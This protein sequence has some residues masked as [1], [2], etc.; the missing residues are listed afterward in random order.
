MKIEDYA[1]LSDTQ[2]AA[3]D[4]MARSIGFVSR[5]S[6]PGRVSPRSSGIGRMADGYSRRR[7]KSPPRAGV[8]AMAR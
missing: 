1:F 8:T 5:N 4:G 6:I 3:L 2:T 7:K